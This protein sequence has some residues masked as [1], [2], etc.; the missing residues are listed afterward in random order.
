MIRSRGCLPLVVLLL[1]CGGEAPP[2]ADVEATI[3][4]RVVFP[5]R[6]T[7]E[8]PM[9]LTGLLGPKEEVPLAFKVGGVVE[10]VAV[11]AGAPVREGQLLA[12]LSLTEIEAAVAAAREG[13]DKAQ[14][15]LARA[16]RLARDSV[17]TAAQLEDARTALAVAEA[18]WRAAT[19]NRRY[20]EVR[21]P[22]DGMVL[23]RQ[24]EVG[25]LVGPGV[26]VFVLGSERSGLVLRVGASDRESVRLR[27]G[28]TATVA[29]DAYPGVDFRGRIERIAV[30]SSPTTG[31]YEVE[32]AVAPG[33]RR[34]AMGLVGRAV[35]VPRVPRGVLTVPAEALLEAE[36]RAATVFVVE[37]G[38]VAR[39]VPVRVLWL[40]DGIAA[41]EAPLDSTSAVV[42]AG[43]TRLTEGTRVRR[44]E[45]RAP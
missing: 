20:A 25:Q 4:V 32:V 3:P 38:E 42:T 12:A 16:E 36:G 31:T 7:A 41:V 23:R 45:E 29:F 30:A 13:R 22:S 37:A 43:A 14:R 28:M 34:L 27:A 26:P 39:R 21:A 8:P 5:Q 24:V 40:A 9:E 1:A 33:G 10:T 18:A 17:A 11:D 44:V 19:F 15:D 35:I 6:R 2:P